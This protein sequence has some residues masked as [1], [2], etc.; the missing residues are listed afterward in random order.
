MQKRIA[1]LSLKIVALAIAAL[2]WFFLPPTY[3]LF[4]TV[5]LVWL[6]FR[7]DSRIVGGIAL[8][9]LIAIP[10][11]LFFGLQPQAE[12]IAVYVF[13]LLCITVLLQ[14]VEFAAG[15]EPVPAP[16]RPYTS[17]PRRIPRQV[18]YMH[19]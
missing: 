4:L 3:A 14:L 13:L 10:L 2:A 8:A 19:A 6:A 15:R 16:Q 1:H 18:E 17:R 9:F 11:L 7:L 5:T 12:T